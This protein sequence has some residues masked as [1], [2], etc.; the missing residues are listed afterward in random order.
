MSVETTMF[1]IAIQALS[2][3]LHFGLSQSSSFAWQFESRDVEPMIA[4][5]DNESP[6]LREE[7]A[8]SL[9]QSMKSITIVA[10]VKKRL[11]V[12]PDSNVQLS[13]HYVLAMQG[14][15]SSLIPLIDSLNQKGHMGYNYLVHLTGQKFGCKPDLYRAWFDKTSDEQFSQMIDERRRR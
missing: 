15:R 2:I 1:R 13:L 4:Q 5:L 12:E 10:A 9:S 3:L 14:E 8:Q 7:A 11:Q 6:Q